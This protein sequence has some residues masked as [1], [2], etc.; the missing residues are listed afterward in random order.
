[1][2][3]ETYAELLVARKTTP[4]QKILP[5]IFFV[6]GAL[7]AV[8]A[9][10]TLASVVV[11]VAIL[12]FV[13]GYFLRLRGDVE[14]EYTYVDKEIVVDRILGKSSRKRVAK[15]STDRMEMIVP[16]KSHRADPYR[17]KE[18]KVTD[19]STGE[20]NA[21]QVSYWMIYENRQ[22]VA[23]TLTREFL[24]AVATTAPRKIFYD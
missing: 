18:Y 14:Y 5:T 21:E 23:F 12:L 9:F 16:V 10:L 17:N 19:Y 11:I 7:M 22:K 8:L 20:E 24:K 6:L 15:Y 1:M 13:A 3:N 2:L 4:I